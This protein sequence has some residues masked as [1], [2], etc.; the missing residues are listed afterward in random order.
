MEHE[1]LEFK[2]VMD[3]D[4]DTEVLARLAHLDLAGPAYTAAVLKYPKR[5]IALRHGAR[6]I[7]QHLGEPPPLIERDPNLKIWSVH[8]IGAKKMQ[9]LGSIDR[10]RGCGDRERHRSLRPRRQAAQATDGQSPAL[11]FFARFG[12]NSVPPSALL[13]HAVAL[14]DRLRLGNLISAYHEPLMAAIMGGDLEIAMQHGLLR[15]PEAALKAL[16][17]MVAGIEVVFTEV[18]ATWAARASAA[19]AERVVAAI[20]TRSEARQEQGRK[21]AAA[22]MEAHPDTGGAGGEGLAE[23]VEALRAHH[24][25]QKHRHRPRGRS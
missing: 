17:A 7:E 8:L 16:T 2:I 18:E 20:A 21:L 3:D 5:N 22:V 13:A 9:Q 4:P 11:V 24:A 23:T 14:L 6:I 1:S 15:D 12:G 19:K 25:G 10:Q